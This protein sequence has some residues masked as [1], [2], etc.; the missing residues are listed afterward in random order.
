MTRLFAY[1]ELLRPR[2]WPKNGFV[3]AGLVFG[4]A[5]GDAQLVAAA[6]AATAG[7]CLGSGAVYAFNDCRDAARDRLHP[8]KRRRPVARGEVSAGAA[9]ALA[10]ASAAA[11]IALAALA[12]AAA[13]ALLAAYLALNIAYTL[14]LKQIP[15][16]DVFVIAAGFMLRLLAGTAGIGIEPSRWL[17]ACGFL[18]ALF[19]GFAK[20]RAEIAQLAEGA[21]EHRAVLAAYGTGFLDRAAFAC[22][23]ATAATYALYTLDEETAVLHGTDD[24][25]LTLPW[26]LFGTFRYLHRLHVRG[27][28]GDPAEELLSDPVLMVAVAGWLG[29]LLWLIG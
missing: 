18:L 3:L 29:T 13:A 9:Y 28:G 24:L 6:A 16:L 14:G 21:G 20:R 12:G 15:V 4:H 8:E 27:A 17:L 19:L 25:I 1:L 5:W 10:A 11:G 22:A 26:V 23:A 2:Q 7:F